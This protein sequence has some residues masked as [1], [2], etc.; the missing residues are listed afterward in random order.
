[1]IAKG[2]FEVRMHAEPPYEEIAGVSHSR[3]TF[4]KKFEGPLE[5]TAKVHMLAARTPTE[6]SA[7]Y[8]AL[9]RISGALEGRKGT[10]SVIHTGLMTRGRSSLLLTIV[11][12]SGTGDLVGISGSMA[13]QIDNGQHFYE[14]DYHFES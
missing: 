6:G 12:D 14:V 10:F 11:P 1:M 3:A 7:A 9:E 8:V 4:D 5:A 2:T 13:I